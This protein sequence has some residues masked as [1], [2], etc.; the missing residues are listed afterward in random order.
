[1]VELFKAGLRLRTA[2]E[3][4]SK[5][6]ILGTCPQALREYTNNCSN[7]EY[8][9]GDTLDRICHRLRVLTSEAESIVIEEVEEDDTLS[10]A[11]LTI[12]SVN[13]QGSLSSI[14]PE[15]LQNWY[16]HAQP[17]SYGDNQ[18]LET[19]LDETIRK[20]REITDF[21]VDDT[22]IKFVENKWDEHFYPRT[23]RAEAYKINIYGP[24][25]H[26]QAH[27]DTPAK[28]LVGT[29]LVGLG[30]TSEMC[31]TFP[32]TGDIWGV[33]DVGSWCAF[34]PSVLHEIEAGSKK[35]Y[36]VTLA[37]KIYHRGEGGT[38][39]SSVALEEFLR[40]LPRP[41]GVLLDFQYS[42]GTKELNGGDAQLMKAAQEAGLKTKLIPVVTEFFA[43]EP[44]HDERTQ[45][46]IYPFTESEIAYLVDQTELPPSYPNMT[47]Y[48]LSSYKKTGSL[49]S[50]KVTHR[51]EYVG[52]ESRAHDETSIYLHYA[53]LIMDFPSGNPPAVAKPQTLCVQL[54]VDN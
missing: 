33:A 18:T 3:N 37:F 7:D 32:E 25:D 51:A 49:W 15:D 48:T 5:L 46:R 38:I 34:Y 17:A 20:A 22:L 27:R 42:I 8:F 39:N 35:G 53:L 45:L 29:F 19:R 30:D 40:G 2:I 54:R 12:N 4:V 23:V 6:P 16:E 31:L 14:T 36:R 26:F 1:M 28:D 11:N 47:F 52:N 21:H 9:E 41:F 50:H 44:Y 13:F 43:I 24:G 10:E